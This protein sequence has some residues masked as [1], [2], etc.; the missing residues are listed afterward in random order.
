M[1]FITEIL[2]QF[3]TVSGQAENVLA[4]IA[5]TRDFPKGKLLLKQGKMCKHMYFLESGFARAFYYKQG[6]D[7][8]SWF[9]VEN[10]VVTS[11]YAF[12][13]QKPSFEN[14]EILEDSILHYISYSQLQ[15][16]YQKF[17]EFNLAVR[18]IIEKYYIEL[19]ERTLSFQIQSARERYQFILNNQP[20]LLQ[21][22]SLGHIASYLGIS[23][24]TLSRVR[25]NI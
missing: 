2:S 6:K 20:G 8:T 18:L 5:E 22:A 25:A 23:Q 24:E 14:I 21:R 19:E 11:M 12:T 7:V 16:L 13:A 10:D 4:E 17:P 9:A 3:A 1:N 15:Q